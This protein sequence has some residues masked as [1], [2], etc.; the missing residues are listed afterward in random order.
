MVRRDA[1]A[2]ELHRSR[3]D[4]LLQVVEHELLGPVPAQAGAGHRV[5]LQ[6]VGPDQLTGLDHLEQQ[7]MAL[8]VEGVPVQTELLGTVEPFPQ[9]LAE[10]PVPQLERPLHVVRRMGD[11]DAIA[12]LLQLEPQSGRQLGSR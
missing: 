3:R 11:A 8:L 2:S 7:V 1:G 6:S 5:G 12:T 9:L 10:H 4:V